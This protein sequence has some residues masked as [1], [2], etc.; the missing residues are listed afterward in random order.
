MYFVSYTSDRQRVQVSKTCLR[1]Q[2]HIIEQNDIK[3]RYDHLPIHDPDW[4]VLQ[5][6]N[7]VLN[8]NN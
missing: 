5:Q 3:H 2:F 8:K 7:N 4:N 1:I 6:Q